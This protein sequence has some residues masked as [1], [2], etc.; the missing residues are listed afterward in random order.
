MSYVSSKN[1]SLI[2][3]AGQ[4]KLHTTQIYK[5]NTK[6]L[7]NFACSHHIPTHERNVYKTY[8]DHKHFT[9]K[10]LTH[11]APDNKAVLITHENGKHH[12]ASGKW[13]MVYDEG[14]EI[15][16]DDY[17]FFAFSKYV[18]NKKASLSQRIRDNKSKWSSMCYST[19]IGW[20]HKKD[21]WGCFYAEKVG[22][23]PQKITNGEVSDKLHVVEGKVE[24]MRFK[25]KDDY[26]PNTSFIETSNQLG[27]NFKN[28]RRVVEQI[29]NIQK[30]WTATNYDEFDNL[31]LKAL[32][33]RAGRIKKAHVHDPQD[34][35]IRLNKAK[36]PKKPNDP[37]S[38][39][40]ADYPDLPKN[41]LKWKEIMPVAKNQ[42]SCGSCYT[43]SAINMLEARWK[44]KHGTEKLFSI[45]HVLNCSVYNQ[46]CKGGYS[47]LVLKFGTEIEMIPKSCENSSGG[48]YSCHKKCT[49]EEDQNRR[50]TIKDY[51]YVGGSYGKC[52]EELLM[53]ELVKNGPLVVSFEPDYHFMMYKNGI[54]RSFEKESYITQ[55]LKKPQWE[56]VAHSVTLVGYGYDEQH[57]E[58][59]WL[60][61]NSWG[62]GWGEDG[63]FRMIR[64]IDHMQIESIGEVGDIVY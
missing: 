20:F 64:G 45:D 21:H 57:Q 39:F 62:Q 9:N 54:Y 11:L 7:Y 42:G 50:Y 37:N 4:W 55:H 1:S 27:A 5:Q 46:G 38:N 33:K 36:A 35:M 31:S 30:M 25:E 29:N 26:E 44:I 52:N 22:E 3:I 40:D 2:K 59:Y 13:T 60:I 41:F 28:H 34:E 12:K 43:V 61:M 16:V 17:S 24:K 23:N 14:F 56:K 19:L 18:P 51:R 63:Y 53:R 10:F 15:I 48:E 6:S 8:I 49:N 47:Y 32:N 58:K